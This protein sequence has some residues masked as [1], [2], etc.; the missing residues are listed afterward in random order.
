M[1]VSLM[2]NEVTEQSVLT[3]D[4]KRVIPRGYS[5]YFGEKVSVRAAG[6]CAC[7]VFIHFM[8]FFKTNTCIL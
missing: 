4:R 3:S 5:S 1:C 2:T 7:A 8:V 6:Q